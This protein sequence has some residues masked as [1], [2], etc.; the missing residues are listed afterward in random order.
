M[1]RLTAAMLL[2]V[3]LLDYAQ[4]ELELRSARDSK[5]LKLASKS[6]YLSMTA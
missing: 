6:S 4:S 3:A 2:Q 5:R 1:D